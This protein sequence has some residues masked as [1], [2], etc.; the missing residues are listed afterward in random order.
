MIMRLTSVLVCLAVGLSAAAAG[1]GR[2]WIFNDLDDVARHPLDPADK[3]ASVLIFY[4]QDCPVSNS[5]APELNHI[6]TSHTNFAFYIVQV[7]PGLTPA[8]AREHARQFGL[9]VPVL[10]DPQ[11]RLVN[12]A[13]ATVTPEAFVFGKNG[14][15]LYHGRIDDRYPALGQKRAAATTHDLSDALDALTAGKSI[16]TRETKAIGC[17]IQ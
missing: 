1:P 13:K 7:D 10:L 6:Y 4:W 16:R 8:A 9:R 17:L 15:I 3:S 11:H 14:E 2:E 12:L 5:Y